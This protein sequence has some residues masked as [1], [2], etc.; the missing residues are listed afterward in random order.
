[1]LQEE[2][3]QQ[4]QGPGPI[5][6]HTLKVDFPGLHTKLLRKDCHIAVFNHS[7]GMTRSPLYGPSPS[8]VTEGKDYTNLSHSEEPYL[9]ALR[10]ILHDDLVRSAARTQ[11]T[12]IGC[13]NKRKTAE[14]EPACRLPRTCFSQILKSPWESTTGC[15]TTS[16][17][18][19]FPRSA[20]R[21]FRR[22]RPRHC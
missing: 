6:V 10:D 3:L 17:R 2:V 9:Q 16:T 20:L 13:R 5:R 8:P 12:S 4:F 18:T 21:P 22:G 19:K 7:R 14:P 11:C 1:M 15:K